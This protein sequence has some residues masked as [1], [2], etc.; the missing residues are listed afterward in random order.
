MGLADALGLF[1]SGQVDLE[2]FVQG[3]A[4]ALGNIALEDGD[5]LLAQA[6][7]LALEGLGVGGGEVFADKVADFSQVAG[8]CGNGG[9]D[10]GEQ[11]ESG[12]TA[13]NEGMVGEDLGQRCEGVGGGGRTGV[14]AD[15][16]DLGEQGW[17]RWLG[18]GEC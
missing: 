10:G 12:N 1:L 2:L 18:W 7:L 14:R 5:Q 4:Q 6:L 3:E 13:G 9:D 11:D 15:L 17:P 16:A 8:Q